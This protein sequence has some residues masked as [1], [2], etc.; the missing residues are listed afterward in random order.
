MEIKNMDE[1]RAAYP[2]LLAQAETAARE[3]G[4]TSGV[5]EERARIQGIEAIQNAVADK[6]LLNAA[7]FGDKPLTAEQLAFQAMQA[8]AAIGANVLANITSDSV[9]SGAAD[10]EANPNKGTENSAADDEA[11]AKKAAADTVAAY[12]MI[13]NGGK[14]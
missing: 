6:N 4:R 12:K 5:A 7:K 13:K 8:Q 9:D 3:E 1:L 11:A 14:K 10:V 2:D